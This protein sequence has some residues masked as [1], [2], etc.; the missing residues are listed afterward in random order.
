MDNLFSQPRLQLPEIPADFENQAGSSRVDFAR[1][2]FKLIAAAPVIGITQTNPTPYDLTA[3]T[4]RVQAIE[5]DQDSIPK[6]RTIL[7]DGVS[8][9]TL[10]VGF[11]DIGST[12]YLVNVIPMTPDADINTVTW[13]LVED[14]RKTNE[15]KIRID[16]TGAAYKFLVHIIEN[17]D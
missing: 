11:E 14:S 1:A 17:T 13:S 10:T 4:Q 12:D 3:L 15:C 16:G 7:K 2:L 9:A 6:M 5:E 8:N